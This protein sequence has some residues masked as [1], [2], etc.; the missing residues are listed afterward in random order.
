MYAN[1]C[2]GAP[3]QDG[4]V[5]LVNG[6]SQFS[7]RVEVCL[8][9]QWGTVQDEEWSVL[10]AYVVCRQLGLVTVGEIHMQLAQVRILC[11][12]STVAPPSIITVL[13]THLVCILGYELVCVAK[14]TY[15]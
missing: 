3:C 11:A 15:V 4:D 6:Y 14:G 12:V 7:G 13:S 10:D 8:S 2:A 1:D 9:E 5:R